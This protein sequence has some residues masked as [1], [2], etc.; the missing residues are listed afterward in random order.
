MHFE[1]INKYILLN[2]FLYILKK[3]CLFLM[4]L[5]WKTGKKHLVRKRGRSNH[6]AHVTLTPW[7]LEKD[8]WQLNLVKFIYFYYREKIHS[9]HLRDTILCVTNVFLNLV[10][11]RLHLISLFQKKKNPFFNIYILKMQLHNYKAFKTL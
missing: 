1:N 6:V 10:H 3:L 5:H 9:A 11:C 2:F 8:N 4:Y 7:R